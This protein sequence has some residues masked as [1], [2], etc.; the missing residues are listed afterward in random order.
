MRWEVVKRLAALSDGCIYVHASCVEL[1][2]AEDSEAHG[3]YWISRRVGVRRLDR[4][5]V[6]P[7]TAIRPTCSDCETDVSFSLS[8][9]VGRASQVVLLG[10]WIPKVAIRKRRPTLRAATQSAMIAGTFSRV[11]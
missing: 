1:V 3:S 4:R 11:Q 2:P 6:E 5:G 9:P 8:A 10:Y 7:Y